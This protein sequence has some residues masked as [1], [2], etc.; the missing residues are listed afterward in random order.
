MSR[1]SRSPCWRL[2]SRSLAS[3][4]R[5]EVADLTGR[6][7]LVI[8]VFGD[9]GTGEAGQYRVGHAMA[10]VCRRRGCDLALMLGD[11]LYENGIEVTA[12]SDVAASR[13][14]ILAQF[15]DKFERPYQ[16]FRSFDDF[17]F[18]FWVALGNHD[19]RRN[20][21]GAML[22]YS[23]FSPLWRL[24]ALHYEIPRLPEWI[25]IHAA[26]TDT[27]VRRDLNGL[28]VASIRRAMCA[29]GNRD[30]WR[31]LFGHH[32]IYNSGHHRNDR[33][34]RRTR[35]LIE[36]PL[37]AACGVH[38]YFAG[39]AHHQEHL[40]APGFEQIIQGA[41]GKTKAAIVGARTRGCASGTSR[42]RSALRSPRSIPTG[43]ASTSTTCSTR[44]R[45]RTTSFC[46]PIAT[47]SARIPECGARTEIGRPDAAPPP[48][49]AER[50]T[51]PR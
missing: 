9:G 31:I 17:H 13:Q 10:E 8:L 39:H 29:E 46:P 28:Q 20:A 11:N 5:F 43:C 32:P 49:P 51:R 37:I 47:W 23:E 15:E 30:R 6:D 12:R 7:A 27:D 50:R 1:R 2:P 40:T 18:W 35:A 14:E 16:G 44:A 25:Q 26:H 41:A 22:T 3:N 45:R 48:C 19:Y 4:G 36:T 34:E 21:V 24:P 38:V 42:E 33:Q